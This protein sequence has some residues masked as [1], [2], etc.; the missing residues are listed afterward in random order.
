MADSSTDHLNDGEQELLNDQ[1]GSQN[2]DDVNGSESSTEQ[3]ENKPKDVESAVRAALSKSGEQSSSSGDTGQEAKV[4]DKA[5]VEDDKSETEAEG[6]LT[7][8]EMALLKPK[9]RR[10]FDRMRGQ[11]SELSQQVETYRPAAEKMQGIQKFMDSSN[12]TNEDMNVLFNIGAMWRNNPAE[13]YKVITPMYEALAHLVGEV[14]PDDLQQQVQ[15]GRISLQYAQ[16]LSRMRAREGFNTQRTQEDRER[17]QREQEARAIQQEAGAAGDA[18]SKLE[19]QWQASDPDYRVKSA[20]IQERIELELLKGAQNGKLPR[21]AQEAVAIAQRVK[22][23]VDA[24]FKRILPKKQAV[25][26]VTGVSTSTGS[27]PAPRSTLEAISRVI[28]Q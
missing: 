23:E 7:D 4:A 21:N 11:V 3:D 8:A 14:L 22:A 10:A 25:Q 2:T 6:D 20:R 5:K 19:Q 18:I 27:K 13:A 1:E 24:E 9:T 15:S 28:G 26:S 12:L 17:Q 16:E